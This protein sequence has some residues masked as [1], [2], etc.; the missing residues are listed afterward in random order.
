[1][2]QGSDPVN[3]G[4]ART[5]TPLNGCNF[6]GSLS[7]TL[8]GTGVCPKCEDGEQDGEPVYQGIQDIK[9]EQGEEAEKL[10]VR[11]RTFDRLLCT[12]AC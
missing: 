3:E 4:R 9:K 5:A 2:K 1:M 11:F 6:S 10:K 7:G 12:S 8:K